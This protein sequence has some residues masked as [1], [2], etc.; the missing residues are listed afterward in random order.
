[1]G[2]ARAQCDPPRSDD[3]GLFGIV[4]KNVP[5]RA[6]ARANYGSGLPAVA[7]PNAPYDFKGYGSVSVIAQQLWTPALLFAI[8]AITWLPATGGQL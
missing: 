3:K 6:E 2:R 5:A 4:R 1:M 7:A 8:A